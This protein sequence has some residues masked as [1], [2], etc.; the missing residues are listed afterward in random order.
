MDGG[1]LFTLKK[2]VSTPWNSEYSLLEISEAES[3]PPLP[4]YLSIRWAL[5]LGSESSS[6]DRVARFSLRKLVD[7]E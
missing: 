1:P 7:F 3:L 4:R 2:L 5:E 6:R